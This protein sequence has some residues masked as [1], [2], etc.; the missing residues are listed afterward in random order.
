MAIVSKL[1]RLG[2]YG[3]IFFV[4]LVSSLYLTSKWIIQREPEVTVP[5]VVGHDTVYAL[6]LLTALGLHI[7]VSGFE[8]SDTVPKNFIAFQDP[9]SGTVLKRDRD[10]KVVLSRGSRMVRVPRLVEMSLREAELVLA[11]NG[12]ERGDVCRVPSGRYRRDGVIAQSPPSLQEVERGRAVH[13]LISDGPE[14]IA[15]AM[16]DVRLLPPAKAVEVIQ[17]LELGRPAVQDIYRPGEPQDVVLSQSP[18]PGYAASWDKPIRLSVNRM[19]RPEE[20]GARFLTIT[21]VVPEGFLR[22]EISLYQQVEGKSI[23]I[24]RGLHSPGER[25]Q[26]LVWA[27]SPDEV[28]VHLDGIPQT[29]SA[30][31]LRGKGWRGSSFPAEAKGGQPPSSPLPGAEPGAPL[32]P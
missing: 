1:L 26:W 2:L 10:V 3:A 9:L 17:R 32:A 7:K 25:L 22:R 15:V 13:L 20:P 28:T 21:Y 29:R 16:P 8:W 5:N 4:S 27:R 23:V 11:Q 24:A 14:P 30:I 6:D 12:L 18:L 19:P 31:G